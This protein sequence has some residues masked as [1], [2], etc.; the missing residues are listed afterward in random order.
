[1]GQRDVILLRVG[2]SQ[3]ML[4]YN[5]CSERKSVSLSHSTPIRQA[6]GEDIKP[7]SKQSALNES[8]LLRV[9][10]KGVLAL[11]QQGAGGE[12]ERRKERG[13]EGT[14]FLPSFVRL[15]SC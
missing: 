5:K 4:Y 9:W 7:F 8:D 13:R 1:M 6:G 2:H 14:F 12:K 3:A 10:K 15:I 11:K